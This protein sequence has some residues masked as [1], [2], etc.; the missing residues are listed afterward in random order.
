MASRKTK[1]SSLPRVNKAS[2]KA[3]MYDAY[4]ELIKML[5]TVD[6][7]IPPEQEEQ[8]QERK[9]LVKKHSAT[10]VDHVLKQLADVKL[11][12]NKAIAEIAERIVEKSEQLQELT[13]TISH[14]E[15]YLHDI[16]Q[17]KITAKTLKQLVH[18]QEF[19]K[20]EFEKELSQKR[21]DW[22]VVFC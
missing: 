14:E 3:E 16:E 1:S 13:K 12:G 9:Q 8:E 17:I 20:K 19:Q 5:D 21:T 7:D 11:S 2:T 15:Q 18:L 10:T 22:E 6:V 4:Q